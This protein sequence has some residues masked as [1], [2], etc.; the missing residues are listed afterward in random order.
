MPPLEVRKLLWDVIDYA[1]YIEEAIA[2]RT[3]DD[4]ETDRN[5]R[6]SVFYALQTGSCMAMAQSTRTSS[7][8][9]STP[10]SPSSSA[11]SAPC[12]AMMTA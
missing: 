6:F 8:A 9:S 3:A 2:G 11:K 5:L 1:S 10:T 7:G 12:S 4:Y